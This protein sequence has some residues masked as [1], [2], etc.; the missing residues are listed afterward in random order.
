VIGHA[1]ICWQSMWHQSR[2]FLQPNVTQASARL[3]SSSTS[4]TNDASAQESCASPLQY[5]KECALV[6]H[7]CPSVHGGQQG[8]GQGFERLVGAPQHASQ[9]AAAARIRVR[10]EG[11]AV[12]E[13][14][15]PRWPSHGAGRQALNAV[16]PCQM[17]GADSACGGSS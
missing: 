2:H 8:A 14:S 15:L 17:G 11:Q 5:R 13:L 10:H 7:S 1:F 3:A 4:C 16:Q 6:Q 12:R 9:P